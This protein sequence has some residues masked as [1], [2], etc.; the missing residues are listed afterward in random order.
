MIS[1]DYPSS[2]TKDP[3]TRVWAQRDAGNPEVVGETSKELVEKCGM[4][5]RVHAS[6]RW[7]GARCTHSS[8]RC[9]VRRSTR[10]PRCTGRAYAV[11]DDEH[12]G[13]TQVRGARTNAK[14]DR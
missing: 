8:V 6:D 11:P 4:S 1:P 10:A 3:S 12:T 9:V 7:T 14:A 13:R 5:G 2:S